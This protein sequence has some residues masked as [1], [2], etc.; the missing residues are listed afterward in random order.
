MGTHKLNIMVDGDKVSETLY[1]SYVD[2]MNAAR[3]MRDEVQAANA[4]GFVVVQ[5]Q[6]QGPCGWMHGGILS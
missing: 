2:M 6:T 1:A 5:Y 3:A 4:G